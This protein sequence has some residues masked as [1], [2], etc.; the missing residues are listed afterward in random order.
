[1]SFDW[2]MGWWST[3]DARVPQRVSRMVAMAQ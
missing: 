2:S 1:V 3:V